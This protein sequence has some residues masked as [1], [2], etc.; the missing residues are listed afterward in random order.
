MNWKQ[1]LI[2]GVLLQIAFF[3]AMFH[4]FGWYGFTPALI[5][6]SVLIMIISPLIPDLDH[7]IGKLHT[8][9][10]GIGFV[11]AII[12]IIYWIIE[13]QTPISFGNGWLHLIILGVVISGA[14]FFNT[15][16][17][18]HRGFWHSIPMGIIYG[19]FVALITGVNIQLGI[20]AFFGFWTH[21]LCDKI[22]FKIK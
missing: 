17:S 14:S 19:T 15:I 3:G 9:I 18:T 5:I 16:F 12:G 8:F 20:L 1:H 4:F 11:I 13:T 6:Q 2:F 21:L 7:P 10:M 22:P